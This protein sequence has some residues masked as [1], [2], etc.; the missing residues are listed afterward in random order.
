MSD[1]V[2]DPAEHGGS[3]AELGVAF[4]AANE[5]AD[6]ER[7]RKAPEHERSR[8]IAELID[9]AEGVAAVTGIR[10]DEPAPRPLALHRRDGDGS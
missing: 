7:W 9:H 8:V 10:N 4:E 5:E 3:G 1:R 2:N 6:L